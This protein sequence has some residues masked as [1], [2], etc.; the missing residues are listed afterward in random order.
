MKVYIL[1]PI[2]ICNLVSQI[3]HIP[4]PLDAEGNDFIQVYVEMYVIRSKR[5]VSNA[6]VCK[7]DAREEEGN[8][9]APTLR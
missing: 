7:C 1:Y 6:N 3:M 2:H 9:N 4:A 8:G 5:L